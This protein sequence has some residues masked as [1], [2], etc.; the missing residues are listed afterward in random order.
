MITQFY[1]FIGYKVSCGAHRL[2][3][4]NQSS[5]PPLLPAPLDTNEERLVITEIVRH[6]DYNVAHNLGFDNIAVLKVDGSF[7]CS[8]DKIYPA[9]L[10]SSEV[11]PNIPLYIELRYRDAEIHLHRLAGHYRVWLGGSFQC[12]SHFFTPRNSPVGQDPAS[13]R[14]H[15]H[16]GL[17]FFFASWHDVAS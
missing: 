12:S 3:D 8:P 16:A 5:S 13:V 6:P 11:S 2:L 4:P 1:S 10:P 14:R 7:S 9:C 15:L 17:Q